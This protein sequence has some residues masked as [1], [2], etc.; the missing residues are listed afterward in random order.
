MKKNAVYRQ[1]ELENGHWQLKI[2][3]FEKNNRQPKVEPHIFS[4]GGLT[5]ICNYVRNFTL[6]I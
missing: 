4:V 2:P 1:K 5:K 6:L 3:E